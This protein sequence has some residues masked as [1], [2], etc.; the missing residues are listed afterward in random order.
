MITAAEKPAAAVDPV[1]LC[2]RIEAV[3]A[4]ARDGRRLDAGTQGAWQVVHGILAFGPEFPLNAK[5]RTT[6]ALAYLLAG[7]HLTGWKLRPGDPGVIAVVEEGSTLG[8]GHPDQWLGYLSQCGVATGDGD[9]LVGGIP[10]DTPLVVGGRSFTVADLLAQAQHDIRPGQEATWT[11]MALSAWLPPDAAWTSGDGEA[12]TTERVVRM[13]AEADIV[14]AACGGAHR[15]YGLAAAVNAHRLATGAE[16]SGGWAAAAAVLDE[17]IDRG[18][19]FQQADGS[20][21]VHSFDR[22]GT[23]PDVFARLGATGHVFEVL[24][25]ALD[26]ERL[27]EPWV[28]RAAERL[29]TLLEQTADLDV[30]CG[31]LYHAAHGL[32]IYR[33]RICR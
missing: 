5:G 22:P 29:V 25:L 10:L 26:D 4:H 33:R 6:P 28:T 21:S 12:W 17:F 9:S 8:Q 19:R 32:A 15:L 23:S 2:G 30:E 1:A 24:A 18:R 11:L 7:G 16:P 14:S 20:F 3:L 31:G 13:E 27:S